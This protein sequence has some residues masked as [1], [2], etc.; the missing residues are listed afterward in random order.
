M[1]IYLLIAFYLPPVIRSYSDKVFMFDLRFQTSGFSSYLL[2][3]TADFLLSILCYT[4]L[5]LYL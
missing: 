2:H 4:R 3:R 1:Y 5:T